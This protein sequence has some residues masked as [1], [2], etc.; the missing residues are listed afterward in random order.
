[1]IVKLFLELAEKHGDK[2]ALKT[3]DGIWTYRELSA[4]IRKIANCLPK[5]GAQENEPIG[6]ALPNCREFIVLLLAAE[7]AGSPSILF[8]AV[9]KSR[10]I[11]YHVERS[12]VRIILAS[13]RM[14]KFMVEAGG[15]K[16]P[17]EYEHIECWRFE[18]E[19]EQKLFLPG[20]FICQMTSGSAGLSKGA[21]RTGEAVLD[22]IKNVLL[23]I[24]LS[25]KDTVLVIPPIH[26]SFGLVPGALSALCAGATLILQDAFIPI[27]I[28]SCIEV[29]KVSV[30]LAVPFMYHMLNQ[31][32]E[33]IQADFSSLRICLTAGAPL[34]ASVAKI[35]FERFGKSI[36]IIYGAT[37]TG[38]MCLNLEPDLETMSVGKAFGTRSIIA[39][40]E[41]GNHLPPGQTGELRTRSIADARAYLYPQ[42]L[43]ETVFHDGWYST[44]D[45]GSVNEEGYVM[46]AGRKS[47]IINVAGLKVDPAEVEKVISLIPEVKEVVVVGLDSGTGTQIV[48]AVVVPTEVTLSK[49]QIIDIC[50]QNLS[51]F[52][53]PR[54]VEFVDEIPRSATGKILRHQLVSI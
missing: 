45:F 53:I 19:N 18:K 28:K 1:M 40:D 52:K 15:I 21:V 6:I 42:E 37:E 12:G 31:L 41:N 30:L 17:C 48:K 8:G 25:E 29:E 27:D 4:E 47:S 51:D 44:G 33:E 32:N 14:A 3:R 5:W 16:Q 39:F 2:K 7:L 43:N 20:D 38:V 22:E 9:Q 49:K 10:E 11:H 23:D 46:I 34:Q 35:F 50:K 13:P 24:Q 26:H 54:V 36:S